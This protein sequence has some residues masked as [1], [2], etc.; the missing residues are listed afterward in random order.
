MVMGNQGKARPRTRHLRAVILTMLAL[1][2]AACAPGPRG[3]PKRATAVS[4]AGGKTR[5]YDIAADQVVWDYAPKGYNLITGDPFGDVEN[6]YVKRGYHRIGSRYIKSLYR[7]YTDDTFTTLKPRPDK[8]SH[9]G[10]L[11]PVIQAEVGDLIVVHFK[12]NTPFPTS[13][14]PHGV[15]YEKSSEGA[16]YNDGTSGADKGD[17]AV[18]PGGTYTYTWSVPERAGPGPGDPSSVMWMY[19]GHTDEISDTYAGLVGPII[20]TRKG[21]ANADGSPKDVDRE[22]ISMFEVSDENQSPWLQANIDKFAKDPR[23]TDPDDPDFQESNLM[24]SING[25]VY[26]NGPMVTLH[27]GQRVRWYLMG[28]G[29]EVDIHTP[30]WHGNV[31]TTGMGMRTDVVELFPGTMQSA[32]MDP[33]DQG[34]WLFHCHVNDHIRAGML[35]RYEVVP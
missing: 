22:V 19:H 31:V 8:W 10:L 17:D 30:H 34:I 33:D 25:Y 20:I 9:L 3:A 1:F 7:E 18:P 26:G 14:H 23:H 15:F 16:L 2:V 32:D 13:L 24:H 4:F 6:T 21:M 29:T 5:A 11:G 28:M 12:N 35:T 27:V